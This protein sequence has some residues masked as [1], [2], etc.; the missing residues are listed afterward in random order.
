MFNASKNPHKS[1]LTA[2]QSHKNAD[3]ILIEQQNFD[4]FGNNNLLKLL[5]KHGHPQPLE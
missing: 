2:T 5:N 4:D 3:F 1:R